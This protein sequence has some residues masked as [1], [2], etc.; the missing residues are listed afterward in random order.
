MVINFAQSQAQSRVSIDFSHTVLEFLNTGH[1]QCIS[2]WE[3]VRAWF[4]E[5]TRWSQ[6]LRKFAFKVNFRSIFYVRLRI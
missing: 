1:S 5:K 4:R 3:V 2:L 6:T